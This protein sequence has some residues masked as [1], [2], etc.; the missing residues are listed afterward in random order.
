MK[1]P[2]NWN[3]HLPGSEHPAAHPTSVTGANPAC[4]TSIPEQWRELRCLLLHL[5]H[6]TK[7]GNIYSRRINM[8]LLIFPCVPPHTDT[9]IP[10]RRHT[11]LHMQLNSD[12]K[13]IK[14]EE[15]GFFYHS[16]IP[17]GLLSKQ[18]N[19][20]LVICER[21]EL[22]QVF[23]PWWRSQWPAQNGA[24]DKNGKPEGVREAELQP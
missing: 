21:S 2:Q 18:S 8:L 15:K 7:S 14:K 5:K 20:A 4:E 1:Y 16:N 22:S 17:V 23:N 24:G 11:S 10:C 12:K 3:L 9:T 19:P 6:R 13:S